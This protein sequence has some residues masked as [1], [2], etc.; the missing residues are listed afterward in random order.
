MS[1]SMSGPPMA[2][3]NTA[4]PTMQRAILD[5]PLTGEIARVAVVTFSDSA[6]CVLTL[7]DMA[8]AR[9]PA[10]S[11]QGGT[12]FAEGF[13]VAREALVD[14]IGG[15]GRGVRYHRPVVFFLSDGQHNAGKDWKGDFDRLRSRED[16]YGAEVVSFG[17]GQANREAI[18]QV[19]TQHAFF[20]TD[21]DPAVAVKEI[22]NTVLLSIKTTSGS[23]QAG[24]AAGLS[25]P[26]STGL[27]PLPVHEN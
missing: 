2:A 3:M 9:M 24:G 23:F 8:H 12:N 16:K 14:G 17:F 5:D 25:V 18:A 7:S 13:R 19:S 11:P 20:A 1:G 6:S 21:V 27:T 4:L 15:L 26:Q 10:L 22:L